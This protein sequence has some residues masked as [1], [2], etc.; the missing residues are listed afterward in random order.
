LS[1]ISKFEYKTMEYL[2]FDRGQIKERSAREMDPLGAVVHLSSCCSYLASCRRCASRWRLSCR[3]RCRCWRTRQSSLD[4]RGYSRWIFHP[5][6][7]VE[8]AAMTEPGRGI[9][10]GK[11]DGDKGTQQD[12]LLAACWPTSQ[13]NRETWPKLGSTD[14]APRLAAGKNRNRLSGAIINKL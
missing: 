2:C 14:E 6:N 9:G 12:R 8:L 10:L 7:T 11:Q 5:E 13:A 4:A 1:L 3:C